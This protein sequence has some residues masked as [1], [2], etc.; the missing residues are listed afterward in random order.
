MRNPAET[1]EGK[2]K[3]EMQSLDIPLYEGQQ[4]GWRVKHSIRVLLV[5]IAVGVIGYGYLASTAKAN[6][7]GCVQAAGQAGL[8]SGADGQRT[9]CRSQQGG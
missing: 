5:L 7:P 3:L 4:K 9:S 1:K 6:E 2:S 8:A